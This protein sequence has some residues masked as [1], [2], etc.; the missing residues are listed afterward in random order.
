MGLDDMGEIDIPEHLLDGAGYRGLNSRGAAASGGMSEEDQLAAA[1]AA[2]L[3]DM[4]VSDN[5]TNPEGGAADNNQISQESYN[6]L[7]AY[8]GGD[9]KP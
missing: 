6:F 5:N 1:I 8:S 4:K 7:D 9:V 2:S 3:Q